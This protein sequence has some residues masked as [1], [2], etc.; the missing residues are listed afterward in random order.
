MTQTSR[1]ALVALLIA[2]ALGVLGWRVLKG[3]EAP[4]TPALA[5]PGAPEAASPERTP[6][7]LADG[8]ADERPEGETAEP[9]AVT[10]T[11]SRTTAATDVPQDALWV[12]GRVE[13]PPALPADEDVRVIA[14]GDSK[15]SE[16]GYHSV[17]I[18]PD[19]SF[20]V[21]FSRD[22]THGELELKA[23]YAYLPEQV[24]LDV[25]PEPDDVVLEAR[26]GGCVE[27]TVNAPE[28]IPEAELP[29]VVQ[30]WAVLRQA[31]GVRTFR[32][33]QATNATDRPHTY[34][35]VLGGLVPNV[36]HEIMV[37]ADPWRRL[38]S[39]SYTLAA[40]ELRRVSLDAAIGA[41]IAGRVVDPA[42]SPL[43]G[44]EI[45]VTTTHTSNGG[46][47]TSWSPP[48][49]TATDGRFLVQGL[50]P[51]THVVHA[52]L[53]DF[54]DATLPLGPIGDAETRADV[55]LVL[56]EGGT[57]SGR[58]VWPDGSGAAQ[59]E[60]D[61]GN[62]VERDL[63]FQEA[64]TWKTDDEGRFELKGLGA[65]PFTVRA[66][67]DGQATS[68]DAHPWT[69]Q[70]K[71]VAVGTHGLVLTLDAGHA[72]TG[73]VVDQ[74][75]AP[76][77]SFRVTVQPAGSDKRDGVRTQ[78]FTTGEADAGRFVLRGLTEGAWNVS[79]STDQHAP[80]AAVTCSVPNADGELT[81]VIQRSASL[82]GRVVDTSGN[83]VAGARVTALV[84]APRS[85][86]AVDKGRW[87]QAQGVTTQDGGFRIEGLCPGSVRVEARKAGFARDTPKR[88]AV[89]PGTTTSDIEL[90]LLQPGRIT[91]HLHP[92]PEVELAHQQVRIWQPNP[93]SLS[94][95][96][97]A[98][99]GPEGQ[100]AFE[101][102]PPG[103]FR[104]TSGA[105][106]ETVTV[107]AGRTIEV[108][109]GL[110]TT[111]GLCIEGRVTRGGEPVAGARLNA[112]L[113]GAAT[114]E[115]HETRSR[116]DGTYELSVSAPGPHTI[117]VQAESAGRS[118]NV[119]VP[120]QGR[121]RQDIELPTGIV[122]G[123]V[124]GTDGEPASGIQLFVVAPGNANGSMRSDSQGRFEV[125]GLSA[126]S[127][128]LSAMAWRDYMT[129]A[130]YVSPSLTF[131]LAEGETLDDLELRLETPSFVEGRV[132]HEDGSS[133]IGAT[134]TL[135]PTGKGQPVQGRTDGAGRYRIYCD[136]GSWRSRAKLERLSSPTS[137]EI[138]TRVGDA[139]T[140]DLT[141]TQGTVVQIVIEGVDQPIWASV[142]EEGSKLR[143]PF[144]VDETLTDI[145]G[146]PRGQRVGPLPPGTYTVVAQRTT[147]NRVE[148]KGTFT[149]NGEAFVE[150]V[151]TMD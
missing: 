97:Y 35:S 48:V 54:R 83:G 120:D 126:G 24:V 40:G 58:V 28:A 84:S 64:P 17:A 125:I 144:Y 6:P 98:R 104:V 32:M 36:G 145:G 106:E 112:Y 50:E 76:Q 60:V 69:A 43:A 42:G 1:L 86:R 138:T 124:L 128:R 140:L 23:R 49:T 80:S 2:A 29:D 70:V 141:L 53:L 136:E 99:T 61:V 146:T 91:G 118:L 148:A 129:V 18:A 56:D 21:G 66:S 109:L 22:T 88:I 150:I 57:I 67:H 26:L 110:S 25:R 103:E 46:E 77:Q 102:V 71:D 73:R 137:G 74:D 3:G 94:Y 89:A 15:F 62:S 85:M 63:R 16:I 93:T 143:F 82:A 51:G 11:S 130:P 30:T 27:L 123:R 59:A 113:K 108:V 131:E 151:L 132:S 5:T 55:E 9:A 114:P 52:T 33:D 119:T 41:S 39:A 37:H 34:N 95:I 79:A 147:A 107:E 92:R 14:K 65:G 117:Y 134:V 19:G 20:R 116:A 133:A 10:S 139:T 135:V 111:S 44:A 38:R 127:Y 47:R 121:V 68:A 72:I 45:R 105:D 13:L 149:V 7:T 90:A 87:L 96:D 115:V 122:R 100:F 12:A 142:S 78:E 4:G 101:D 31:G 75:G 81:I 8:A